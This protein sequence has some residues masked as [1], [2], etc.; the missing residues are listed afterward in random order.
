M[1]GRVRVAVLCLIAAAPAGLAACGDGGSNVTRT[2]S[3]PL[4]QRSD[5][6][7]MRV[8]DPLT[9]ADLHRVPADSP[10]ATL[11]R[12]WFYAQWGSAPI[13]SRFHDDRVTRALSAAVVA[14]VYEQ[15]R[16]EMVDSRPRIR[17]VARRPEGVLLRVDLLT[18]S[19]PPRPEFLLLRRG[20]GGWR[21]IYDS[22]LNDALVAYVQTQTQQRV[23]PQSGALQAIDVGDLAASRYRAVLLSEFARRTP[24]RRPAL[25]RS[26]G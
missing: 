11:L 6:S 7:L 5:G 15:Q 8:P 17:S 3:T 14:G 16:D 20:S 19:A 12:L 9:V 26:D 25:P 4:V 23:A 21:I 10:Q 2:G 22:Y 24:Q 18:A 13:L 1:P